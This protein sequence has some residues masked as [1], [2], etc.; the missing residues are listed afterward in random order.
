MGYGIWPLSSGSFGPQGLPQRGCFS[1]RSS[2][3]C[4]CSHPCSMAAFENTS[5]SR[6]CLIS[7]YM[8]QRGCFQNCLDQELHV[9]S[10]AGMDAC[11]FGC[12]SIEA[13]TATNVVLRYVNVFHDTMEMLGLWDHNIGIDCSPCRTCQMPSYPSEHDRAMNPLPLESYD[14]RCYHRSYRCQ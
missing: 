2:R 12:I 4:V 1:I 7:T 11:R 8:D 13:Y 6:I 9:C 5:C 3:K 10:W 14:L